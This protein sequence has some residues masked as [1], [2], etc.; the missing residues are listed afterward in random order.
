MLRKNGKFFSERFKVNIVI[1]GD[2]RRVLMWKL[3]DVQVMENPKPITVM[4]QMHYSNIFSVGFSNKFVFGLN[5]SESV[6]ILLN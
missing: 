1:G 3:N 2:D 6:K 5:F 4:R